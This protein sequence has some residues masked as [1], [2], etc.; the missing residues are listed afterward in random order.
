L[1]FDDAAWQAAFELLLLGDGPD[2]A[3]RAAKPG[4]TSS[5]VRNPIA[6]LG[7]SNVIRPAV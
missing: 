6:N 5:P 7:L 2:G 1:G 3:H 4:S